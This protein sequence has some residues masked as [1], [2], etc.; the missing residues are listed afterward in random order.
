MGDDLSFKDRVVCKM[1]SLQIIAEQIATRNPPANNISLRF[2][3][4]IAP[5]ATN[6]MVISLFTSFK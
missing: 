6:G 4:L 2:S 1:L 5:I 3:R